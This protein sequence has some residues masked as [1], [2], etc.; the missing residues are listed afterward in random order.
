MPVPLLHLQRAA[1]TVAHD[2]FLRPFQHRPRHH[3]LAHAPLFDQHRPHHPRQQ[4]A[5]QGGRD[6]LTIDPHQHIR[7]A[8]LGQFAPLVKKQHIEAARR[9]RRAPGGVVSRPDAGF[10]TE[11]QVARCGGIVGQQQP[12]RRLQGRQG[13]ALR[14]QRAVRL[15]R[16]PQTP[17]DGGRCHGH[18]GPGR[19]F[20]ESESKIRRRCPKARQVAIEVLHAVVIHAHGLE[21]FEVVVQ[22]RQKAR[23][24]LALGVFIVGLAVVDDAGPHA[25]FGGAHAVMFGLQRDG[26]DRHRHAKVADGHAVGRRVKP[27]DRPRINPARRAFQLADDFHGAALGRAG[28]RAARVEGGED[29]GQRH[30]RAQAGTHGG[31]HLQHAAVTA[32]VEQGGRVDAAGDGD[33]TEVVAQQVDD[34]QVFGAVFR[35]LRQGGGAFGVDGF[36]LA[37]RRGALHRPRQQLA[38]RVAHEQFGRQR[39]HRAAVRQGDQGAIRHRLA[40]A[41]AG[42]QVEQGAEG[43]EAQAVGKI[44]LVGVAGGDVVVDA[45]QRLRERLPVDGAAHGGD[46]GR[47]LAAPGRQ[48]VVDLRRR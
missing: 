36:T 13:G 44:D 23:F 35:V 9:F 31:R 18:R 7:A 4:P 28:D 19:V 46:A 2:D 48:P 24:Q 40:R 41:Q 12:H 14:A 39:H 38:A 42:V 26:T 29:V 21:Q 32:H 8:A 1:Q 6:P 11:E 20:I 47:R 34:H 15:Q 3:P 45:R 16:Q 27:A 5:R 22:A 30:V 37:G 25:H 10:V 43:V 33:A 17:G